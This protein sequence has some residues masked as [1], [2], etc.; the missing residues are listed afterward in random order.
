[1]NLT[2]KKIL[3]QHM[4]DGYFIIFIFFSGST[5]FSSNVPLISMDITKVLETGAALHNSPGRPDKGHKLLVGQTK[6]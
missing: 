4:V 3:P 5:I 1:M 6:A 2:K